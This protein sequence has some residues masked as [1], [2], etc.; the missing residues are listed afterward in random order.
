M[1]HHL[2]E[3]QVVLNVSQVL[4]NEFLDVDYTALVIKYVFG[5]DFPEN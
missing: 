3:P 5:S 4:V 1:Y 2:R